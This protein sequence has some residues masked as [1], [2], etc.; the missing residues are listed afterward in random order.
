MAPKVWFKLTS[1]KLSL[2]LRFR[3]TMV[4]KLEMTLM[5]CV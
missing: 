4:T 5:R 3:L 2:K 1:F